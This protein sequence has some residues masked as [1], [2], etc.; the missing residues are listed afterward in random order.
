MI[1]QVLT[2][3]IIKFRAFWDVL[4]WSKF[5]VD[6]GSTSQ[7]ALNFKGRIS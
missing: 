5:D 1:F 4:P 7:K 6:I 2:A 3:A